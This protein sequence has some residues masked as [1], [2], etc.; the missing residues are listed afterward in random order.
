MHG[1]ETAGRQNVAPIS[2]A[3]TTL[4]SNLGEKESA[5]AG[6]QKLGKVPWREIV[7]RRGGG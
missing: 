7:I 6:V 4:E 1:Q 3:S 5:K 2:C